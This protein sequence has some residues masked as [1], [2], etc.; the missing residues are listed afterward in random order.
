MP[1]LP[2]DGDKVREF[3]ITLGTK[4]RELLED[5]T[6]TLR[7]QSFTESTLVKEIT[8]NPLAMIAFI[9]AVLTLIE[10]FGIETGFATPIDAYDFLKNRFKDPDGSTGTWQAFWDVNLRSDFERFFGGIA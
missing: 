8:K 7:L 5:V 4:E 2:V 10:F 3:R 1:R 6:A 9:E